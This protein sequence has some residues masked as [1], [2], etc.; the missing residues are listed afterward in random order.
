MLKNKI[1]VI[2]GASGG[3]GG[4]VAH[5]FAHEGPGSFSPGVSRH[6]SMP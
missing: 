6:R 5:A 3:I 4:A 1:A 2:Y